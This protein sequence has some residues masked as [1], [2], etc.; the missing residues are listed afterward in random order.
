MKSQSLS[1]FSTCDIEYIRGLGAVR[2]DLP[3]DRDGTHGKSGQLRVSNR[4]DA[5]DFRG[6]VLMPDAKGDATVEG[7]EGAQRS[8]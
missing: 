4:A 1:I 7:K 2:P 3:G 5:V 6:T 8:T